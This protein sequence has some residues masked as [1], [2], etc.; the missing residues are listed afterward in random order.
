MKSILI[1]G[2]TGLI[3][4]KLLDSIDKSVYNV[5]VLTRKKSFKELKNGQI[6]YKFVKKYNIL[7]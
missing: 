1:T 6:N 2:G 4:S 5:Y 7:D 3:G